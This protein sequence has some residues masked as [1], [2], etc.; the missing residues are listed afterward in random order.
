MQLVIS[1]NRVTEVT[2]VTKELIESSVIYSGVDLEGE[3]LNIYDT[4]GG[5]LA[6]YV[7][8]LLEGEQKGKSKITIYAIAS[9]M[10]LIL[11]LA[12]LYIFNSNTNKATPI[13]QSVPWMSNNILTPVVE[14]INKENLKNEILNDIKEKES[15]PWINDNINNNIS[16]ESQ[17]RI[18]EIESKYLTLENSYNILSW[19]NIALTEEKTALVLELEN[20]EKI[21]NEYSA[22]LEQKDF[23]LYLKKDRE[24]K[25]PNDSFIYYLW[26]Y[27]YKNCELTNGDTKNKCKEIY[28]N[29]LKK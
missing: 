10:V 20:K 4:E 17:R 28:Y 16:L 19:K 27:L 11:I 6:P 7:R 25:E 24:N 13:I 12:W 23:E 8:Y 14:T 29:F 22:L 3:E 1:Q 9:V 2:E 26:E 21:I 5:K 18:F 15:V